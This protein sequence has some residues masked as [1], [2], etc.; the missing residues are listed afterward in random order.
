[1]A[2]SLLKLA[3]LDWQLPDFST[4]SRRKKHL[5]MTIGAQPTMT[6]LHLLVN[7]TGIKML[8]VGEWKTK[9]RIGRLSLPEA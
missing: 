3:G 2:Q 5:S 6:G 9:K 4:V 8:G 7:S 1:M